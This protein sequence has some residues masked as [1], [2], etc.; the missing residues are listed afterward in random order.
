MEELRDLIRDG[1]V[2]TVEAEVHEQQEASDPLDSGLQGGE[3]PSLFLADHQ[4]T[5]GQPAGAGPSP[6]IAELEDSGSANMGSA[7]L[8][9]RVDEGFDPIDQFSENP[10]LRF[11]ER[12][13]VHGDGTLT[14]PFPLQAGRGRNLLHLMTVTGGF[15]VEY[16]IVDPAGEPQAAQ[17]EPLPNGVARVVLLEDFDFEQ[18]QAF[19]SELE[20]APQNA[21]EIQVAD[22]LVVRADEALMGEV[23]QF[24]E[25][26]AGSVPQIEIE[27][28]IVE[29]T[30][31]EE[32]DFGVSG[33]EGGAIFDFPENAAVGAF[34]FDVPNLADASEALLS[35]GTIADGVQISAV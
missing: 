23:Q 6:S 14:K 34:G 4:P 21:I 29:V 30:T 9:D 32:F 24:V 19:N 22:W 10:Y 16:R 17:S 2:A 20:S 25:V 27:A 31:T 28:R 11:G 3:L 5:D 33:E 12:I 18:Y 35:V 1:S 15:P 26:F 7:Y 13:L 8:A